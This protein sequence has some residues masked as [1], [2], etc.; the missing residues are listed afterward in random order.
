MKKQYTAEEMEQ[1]IRILV[2]GYLA[3]YLRNG[4]SGIASMKTTLT[5]RK[6]IFELFDTVI[7]LLDYLHPNYFKTHRVPFS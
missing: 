7:H 5:L 2:W 6:I 3:E 1:G 4:D